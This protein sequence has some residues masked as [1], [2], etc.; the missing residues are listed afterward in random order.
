MKIKDFKTH[1]IIRS[2]P[3][4]K[5]D[6]RKYRPELEHDFHERCAYCNLHKN[7][8]TTQFEIDHFIPQGIFK[9]VRNDLLTEYSN[10]VYSCPK[11]NNAKGNQFSGD[12]YAKNVK[13]EKFY[14]P[15]ETDY[16][17]VFYRNEYGFI[18]SD[19]TKGREMI[20]DIKLYR[21]IHAL[22]WICEQLSEIREK[23]VF[24]IEQESDTERKSLL[25][26]AKEKVTNAYFEKDKLFKAV[27]NNPDFLDTVK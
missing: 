10:L 1:V 23:L 24:A 17:S 3:T 14:D 19:D 16:N 12:I 18:E 15:V 11:C 8:I 7:S 6:Y 13:N 4:K 22:A 21:N 9:G 2:T 5:T 26:E 25:Q 20:E 27:Y